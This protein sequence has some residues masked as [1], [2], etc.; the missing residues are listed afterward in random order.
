LA[1]RTPGNAILP[2]ATEANGPVPQSTI[3]GGLTL[4]ARI[5]DSNISTALTGHRLGSRRLP[6]QPD[7]TMSLNS[8]YVIPVSNGALTFTAGVTGKGS[9][10][11]FQS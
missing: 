11:G 3:G 8:D 6:F 5:T 2:R 4:H 10:I 1:S 7:W 9:W